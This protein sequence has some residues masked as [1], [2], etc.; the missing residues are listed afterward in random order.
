MGVPQ[1]IQSLKFGKYLL[2]DIHVKT[3]GLAAAILIFGVF[4]DFTVHANLQK[5]HCT[6]LLVR[7]HQNQ[8]SQAHC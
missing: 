6:I 8:L 3:T 5:F 7:K 4:R 1:N 2:L